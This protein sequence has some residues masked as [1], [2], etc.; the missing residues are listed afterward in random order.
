MSVIWLFLLFSST[1]LLG[2][3]LLWLVSVLHIIMVQTFVVDF[4]SVLLGT[5]MQEVFETFSIA[6]LLWI[7]NDRPDS[8]YQFFCF[9]LWIPV[10]D[11]R[12]LWRPASVPRETKVVLGQNRVRHPSKPLVLYR[13]ASRGVPREAPS[14]STF[15]ST[16]ATGP[17][18]SAPFVKNT[19]GMNT[20]LKYL[21]KKK[22]N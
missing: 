7:R 11:I 8:I 20:Q 5:E 3:S 13:C 9:F 10:C 17:T 21:S 2:L 12:F 18:F 15:V 16:S 6:A 14:L 22:K 19:P 4:H 1:C